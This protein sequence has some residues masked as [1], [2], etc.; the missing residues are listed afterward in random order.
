MTPNNKDYCSEECKLAE[1]KMFDLC[2]PV[3]LVF[4]SLQKVSE[5]YQRDRRT[6]TK[7]E[8]RLYTLDK[9]KVDSKVKVYFPCK[10]C[11]EPTLISK[12]RNG[13]CKK[14]SKDGRSRKEQGKKISKL[15]TGEGNPNYTNGKS[16]RNFRNTKTS[17]YRQWRDYIV[18]TYKGKFI[19]SLDAH[20]IIPA[21]LFPEFR[22][23]QWNGVALKRWHHIELHRRRLDLLLLPKLYSQSKLDALNLRQY[24]LHLPEV[25]SVLQLPYKKYDQC[26]L[27]RVVPNNYHKL[28]LD[29]HP[30]F[31]QRVLFL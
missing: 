24:F 27:I 22:F 17:K 5:Y 3:P 26:E 15:Y 13:Y 18:S 20:H 6:I 23:A 21:A 2:G 8:G 4:D 9:S 10:I 12:A 25:Q 14:C 30:E 1:Q 11:S 19:V 16:K 31:A 29:L 7:Y 28:L